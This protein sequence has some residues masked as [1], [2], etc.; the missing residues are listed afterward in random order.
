MTS[1]E[2][3]QRIVG[4]GAY[5]LLASI[6]HEIDEAVIEAYERAAQVA[7]RDVNNALVVSDIVDAIRALKKETT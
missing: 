6:K 7:E 3:A 2:R 5:I 4:T 1:L